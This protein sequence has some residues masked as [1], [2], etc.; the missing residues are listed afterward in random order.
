MAGAQ[1]A[2]SRIYRAN[3]EWIE[4]S[5][6]RLPARKTIKVKTN[7]GP[8]RLIGVPQDHITYIVRK[9]VRA[10]SEEGARRE[11][12]R[13]RF[14]VAQADGVAVFHGECGIRSYVGFDLNVPAQTTFAKLITSGGTIT[15]RNIAGKIEAIT[16]S[17]SIQLDG[18]GAS[19]FASSG[20]GDIEIGSV[21]GDVQAETHGGNIHVASAGGYVIASSGGGAVVIGAGKNMKLQTGAGPIAVNKCTGQI[22]ASTG[23]GSIELKDVDGPAQVESGGGPVHVG[24]VRGG[25]RVDTSSGQIVVSLAKGPT[26]T[27]SRL[28]TSAGNI[29]VYIPA[30]L[31]V[32]I[33]AAVEVPRGTGILTEFP[34]LKITNPDQWGSRETFAEGALNGGGPLL[35]VHTSKGTIEFKRTSG[36]K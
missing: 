1:D 14:T 12:A 17:E 29:V 34:G 15:A 30:D 19:A 18:I 6:G 36:N 20:G 13:L 33:R 8:I 28:E 11:F 4:E 21:G 25:L 35:H 24:Q 10:A 23:G 32:T 31:A 16:G 9:H 22:K 7:A 5:V 2:R 3:G 26:F 27:D